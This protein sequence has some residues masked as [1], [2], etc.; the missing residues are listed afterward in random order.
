MDSKKALTVV[1]SIRLANHDFLN[2]FQLIQLHLELGNVD[3]AK[4]IMKDISTKYKTYSSLNKL[5]LPKTVEWLYTCGWRF[6][7][8]QLSINCKA[9]DSNYTQNDDEIVQYLEE[10]LKHVYNDLDP[11]SEQ[12]LL[13]TIESAQNQFKLQFHLKG[14][15]SSKSFQTVL[16]E[17]IK[18]QTYEETQQSWKYELS[19]D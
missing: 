3:E 7:A 19:S 15:W 17:N 18:V 6:P 2:H 16:M 8:I 10:T 13:I 1:E 14:K 12:N 9:T 4:N 11:F 5:S